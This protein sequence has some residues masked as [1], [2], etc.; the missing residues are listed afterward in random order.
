M[1]SFPVHRFVA[2]W[3]T[4]SPRLNP[5][6]SLGIQCMSTSL[7]NLETHFHFIRVFAIVWKYFDARFCAVHLVLE[8]VC[9]HW[10]VFNPSFFLCREITNRL[11]PVTP[12]DIS[13]LKCTNARKRC[14]AHAVKTRCECSLRHGEMAD[15]LLIA[16]FVRSAFSRTLS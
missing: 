10:I 9:G 1:V 14:T 8:R 5:N 12:E 13:I 3:G 2:P 15:T 4:N 11:N 6:R 16:S 7:S